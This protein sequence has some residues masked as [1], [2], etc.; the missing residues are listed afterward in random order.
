MKPQVML[1]AGDSWEQVLVRMT[2]AQEAGKATDIPPAPA[3][4]VGTDHKGVLEVD[5]ESWTAT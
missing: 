5:P 1:E 2:A 3:R 4:G